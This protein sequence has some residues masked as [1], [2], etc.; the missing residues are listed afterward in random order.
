MKPHLCVL[1]LLGRVLCGTALAQAGGVVVLAGQGKEYYQACQVGLKE[2]LEEAATAAT[3][4]TLPED[5]DSGAGMEIVGELQA[6]NPSVVATLGTQATRWAL[7]RAWA[8]DLLWPV[9][10]A[11]VPSRASL[12]LDGARRD[13]PP[14][15]TGVL[16]QIPLERQIDAIRRLL[17][18]ARRLGVVFSD[19]NQQEVARLRDLCEARGLLCESSRVAE[20]RELAASFESLSKAVDVL[21]ALPDPVVYSGVS[22]KYVLLFSLDRRIPLVGFSEAYVKGGA[23][24]G[25]YADPEDV[26]RQWGAMVKRILAGADPGSI[27]LEFPQ[28][29][30]LGWNRKVAG[31][32]GIPEPDQKS[33]GPGVVLE[34][35]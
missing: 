35:F 12:G 21:F 6:R 28:K 32:L 19:A 17:P 4:L 20:P 24:M 3:F 31:R 10:F 11:M 34:L 33:L 26:G 14:S 5:V 1:L 9:C 18:G 16:L 13:L 7:E 25:L 23:I 27:P 22:A 8:G 30:R 29:V 2:T 15:L